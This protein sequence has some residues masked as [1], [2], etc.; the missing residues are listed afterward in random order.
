[1]DDRKLEI[2][3]AT[4]SAG[5]HKPLPS[6]PPTF[7]CSICEGSVNQ[8]TAAQYPNYVCQE[9]DEQALNAKG[10]PATMDSASDRG[11]NPVFVEGIKCFRR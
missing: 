3:D 5:F 9:C 8:M 6:R 2:E 10:E 11:D 7:T 4:S 1:M